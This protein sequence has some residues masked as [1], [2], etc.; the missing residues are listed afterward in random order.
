MRTGLFTTLGLAASLAAPAAGQTPVTPA[1]APAATLSTFQ[2]IPEGPSVDL[3]LEEAVARA[4]EHNLDLAVARVEP[5]LSTLSL[6]AVYAIYQPTVTSNFSNRSA[7]QLPTSLLQGGGDRINN[8]QF[9]WNSGVRQ[10]LP[11]WGGN[12][13]VSWTNSKLTTSDTTATRNPS[14]STNLNATFTQPLLRNFKT[15]TNRTSLLTAKIGEQIADISLKASVVNTEA[16]VRNAYWD[17][18]YATQAVEATKRSLDLA[19]KLVQDNRTRVEIGTMAPIDVVQAQAEEASRRQA[20]VTAEATRRTTELALKRLIVSGTG[21]PLWRALITPVDRPSPVGEPVDVEAAVRTA[22]QNRTD[23][24]IARKTLESNDLSIRNLRNQ[25]L[26]DL[27]VV[28]NYQLLGRGGTTFDRFPLG[29]GGGIRQ[30]IPGG[31]LDALTNIRGFDAPTW[32]LSLNLSYPI[33]TTAS[34]V[35]LARARLQL[36]QTQAQI[37]QTELQVATDVTSAALNVRN[38]LES[39][40]AATAARELAEKRLDAEQSKFDVGMST[41]YQV[42]QAQRDLA[43]AQSSELRAVLNYRK[44]LVD[45]QRVQI[46]GGAARVTAISA[47]GA[48]GGA[49]G[50]TGTG[51]TT[52]TTTTGGR[53]GGS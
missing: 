46:T 5:Q 38:S 4:L 6:A 21:D 36:Q 9:D 20:L 29:Q 27:N 22:L 31:Y 45:F 50:G 11:R 43:D 39:V 23:I 35:N 3:R 48:G 14:Y 10:S 34:D 28:A 44:S 30:V 17:L 12:Y 51:T 16:N 41:N 15:D 40:Q 37:R 52:T 33:G 2:A 7:V 49:V 18:V 1:V 32:N 42:V 13:V 24:E 53:T 26:P 8:D 19:S 47:G 25:T